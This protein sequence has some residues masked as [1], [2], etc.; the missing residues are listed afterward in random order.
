MPESK[1][2]ISGTTVDDAKAGELI[3]RLGNYEATEVQPASTVIKAVPVPKNAMIT[4]IDV[5]FTAF[6]AGRT[7]NIG[8]EN[9]PDRFFN[10]IDVSGA[11]SVSLFGNGAG[12]HNFIYSEDDTIDVTVLGNTMPIGATVIVNVEYKIA[13]SIPDEV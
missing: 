12:G 1:A 8:D 10:G 3:K 7:V 11:G 2:V 13:G 6:G 4:N 5:A 9:D